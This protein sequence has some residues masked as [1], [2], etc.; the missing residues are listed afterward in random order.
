MTG[1]ALAS[2]PGKVILT[3]EH[4]VVHGEPSLVM[5]VDLR[6][7]VEARAGAEGFR[8]EAPNLGLTWSGEGD[9]PRPLAPIKL[10]M[11]RLLEESRSRRGLWVRVTS[12]IPTSAGLGSSAAV[13]VAAAASLCTPLGEVFIEVEIFELALEAERLVHVN[14]SGVDPLISTVGGV[15]AYRRGEG[16]VA[17]EASVKPT[18]IVGYTGSRRPTGAMVKRVERLR[19]KYP[20]VMAP[21]FHAGGHLTIEAAEALREGDLERLGELLNVNHGLLCA[22]GVST[23]KLDKLVYAARGAGALGAKLTGAGGGGCMIALCR[24]AEADKVARAIERSGGRALKVRMDG[25]GVR[26]EE[27]R[28]A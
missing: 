20:E 13:A 14:P 2:A 24:E 17:V 3:G 26:L 28:R 5:A 15:V 1:R 21:L 6:A 19:R 22:I 8:I 16:Y 18:I 9:V 7:Y 25:E 12:S 11:D 23:R 4:F 10:L 27:V